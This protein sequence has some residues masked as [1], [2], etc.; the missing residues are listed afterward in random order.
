[1]LLGACPVVN[2][3]HAEKGGGA[4]GEGI[5]VQVTVITKCIIISSRSYSGLLVLSHPRDRLLL[6][7]APK[8]Y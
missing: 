7:M 5:E 3:V 2:R 4:R 6:L 1:M 8:A